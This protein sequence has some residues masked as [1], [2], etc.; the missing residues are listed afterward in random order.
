M[1][2]ALKRLCAYRKDLTHSLTKHNHMM[3]NKPWTFH[4]TNSEH[5][6]LSVE[7]HMWIVLDYLP[8]SWEHE[9]KAFTRRISDLTYNDIVSKDENI[10]FDR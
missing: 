1:F 5:Y 10:D 7:Q 3:Y 2:S 9:R 6:E 8:D 4:V